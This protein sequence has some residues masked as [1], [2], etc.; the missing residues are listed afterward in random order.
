[1]SLRVY[2]L[3][4]RAAVRG[5]LTQ[6]ALTHSDGSALGSFY[7]QAGQ[8]WG[9]YG[10]V[11]VL[12]S[13]SLSQRPHWS[14]RRDGHT[15]SHK[16]S[17]PTDQHTPRILY[18]RDSTIHQ[19]TS[20]Y[21]SESDILPKVDRQTEIH[22]HGSSAVHGSCNMESITFCNM[23]S[24]RTWNIEQIPVLGKALRVLNE[25]HIGGDTFAVCKSVSID[26]LFRF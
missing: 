6:Q 16:D 12:W 9:V 22:S 15:P 5:E 1:M 13:L 17:T 21:S 2:H 24:I 26:T 8:R 10:L 14:I 4:S 25:Y 19:H 18:S 3:W 7:E 23:E 20:L 11:K